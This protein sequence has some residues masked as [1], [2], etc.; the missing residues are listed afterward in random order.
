MKKGAI[1]Y[2]II[3]SAIIWGAVI[4]GCSLKLRGTTYYQEISPVLIGG[5]LTHLFFIWGPLV[6]QF[7]KK[8]NTNNEES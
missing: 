1:G 4:I 7:K 2:F 8:T 3:A 5:M 6:S